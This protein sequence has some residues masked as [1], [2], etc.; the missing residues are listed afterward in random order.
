MILIT[1]AGGML[2]QYLL[3]EFKGEKVMTLGLRK[4]SDFVA[5]LTKE[6]GWDTLFNSLSEPFTTVV[7]AAGSEEEENAMALN[8]EGTS[9]LL[10]ALESKVPENLVFISSYRVYSR[11]AGENVSEEANTW[12]SDNVGRSKARAEELV[13]DWCVKRDVNLSII[14]PARMFGNGVKGETLSLFNDALRGKY[15]HVRG[16][17]ARVSLVCALDVAKAVKAVHT[18]GGL[19]NAADPNPV[20]FIDMVE[21]LTANAGGKKRMTHLP[22]PWAEW[23]WRLGR[24]IP[25][26]NRNLH[27]SVV[28]ARMKSLT[29]DG[30]LL[31]QK[32]G[33]NYHDT[34][35]VIERSD[36]SYPYKEIQL[37]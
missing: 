24:W 4:E 17:D 7:H 36:P 1:G 26:I 21:A 22:A 6:E 32:A 20:R 28:E 15:I 3:D 9:R 11:D 31:A 35:S 37:K 10:R 25:S 16:N 13:R 23:L 29:L 30:S 8:L 27:P 19:Y 33:I 14:R 34:I 2:G 12:A 18:L 5:D